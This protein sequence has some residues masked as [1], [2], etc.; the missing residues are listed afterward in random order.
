ME[1]DAV[2]GREYKNALRN[3]VLRLSMLCDPKLFEA[4]NDN[5]KFMGAKELENLKEA[6]EKSLEDKYPL[7]TQLPGRDKLVSFDGD[8]YKV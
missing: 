4:L 6:F 1:K 3:E 8:E 5:A 7:R 2:L